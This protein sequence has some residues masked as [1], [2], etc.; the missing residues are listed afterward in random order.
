MNAYPEVL[1]ELR[2]RLDGGEDFKTFR[3]D[4]IRSIIDT[5]R[6]CYNDSSICMPITS[7]EIQ[8]GQIITFTYQFPDENEPWRVG[9]I[10]REDAYVTGC[11]RAW[12]FNTEWVRKKGPRGGRGNKEAC[13]PSFRSYKI[14]GM[15]YPRVITG[16]A[17]DM[18]QVPTGK[19]QDFVTAGMDLLRRI[20]GGGENPA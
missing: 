10:P 17:E 18:G 5:A 13:G 19:L 6:R 14:D 15:L 16:K 20:K 9:V 2:H 8:P 7:L 4:F 11:W 12:T 3:P 1:A